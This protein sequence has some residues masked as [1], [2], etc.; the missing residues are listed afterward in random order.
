MLY[1]TSSLESEP[2]VWLLIHVTPWKS[3]SRIII[4]GI[5]IRSTL[6]WWRYYAVSAT[7]NRCSLIRNNISSES[8]HAT[9]LYRP[10]WHWYSSASFRSPSRQRILRLLSLR[11]IEY[12]LSQRPVHYV[13]RIRSATCQSRSQDYAHILHCSD[14]V[15][16]LLT[17]MKM[18]STRTSPKLYQL[19]QVTPNPDAFRK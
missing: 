10:I 12:A 15:D 9:W 7:G 6:G 11:S 18:I 17:V 19:L 5:C 16:N 8:I 4:S 13:L 2:S 3:T 14:Y 1:L